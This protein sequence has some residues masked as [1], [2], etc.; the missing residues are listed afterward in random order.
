M[1]FAGDEENG[2]SQ[3]PCADASASRDPGGLQ[4]DDKAA[5]K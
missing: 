4:G 2:P 5:I 1:H 3:E